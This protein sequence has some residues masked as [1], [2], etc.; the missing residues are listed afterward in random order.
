MIETE[1]SCENTD[2]D[3]LEKTASFAKI[4]P[5]NSSRDNSP[6]QTPKI[7]HETL[8][9]KLK[10]VKRKL[11]SPGLKLRIR[12]DT[13]KSTSKFMRQRPSTPSHEPPQKFTNE[14]IS[15]N[16]RHD[17]ERKINMG[18][19]KNENPNSSLNSNSHNEKFNEGR[20]HLVLNP[21]NFGR[22]S[23]SP[24]SLIIKKPDYKKLPIINKANLK[25]IN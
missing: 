4:S 21:N 24:N 18:Y 7:T 2:I 12:P 8:Q 16:N 14:K 6:I 20:M 15:L 10:L 25:T 1:I 13:A 11:N 9:N 22:P 23:Q 17:S 5:P 3:E 19:S